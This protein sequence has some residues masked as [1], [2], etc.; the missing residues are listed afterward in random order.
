MS[1]TYAIMQFATPVMLGPGVHVPLSD[2]YCVVDCM[3]P[4]VVTGVHVC[5]PAT[6]TDVSDAAMHGSRLAYVL[7]D[8]I[9]VAVTTSYAHTSVAR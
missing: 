6:N 3:I 5:P 4:V 9:P 2:W 8:E 7:F 1:A